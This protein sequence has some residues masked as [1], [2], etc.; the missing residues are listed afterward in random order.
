MSNSFVTPA[1]VKFEGLRSSIPIFCPDPFNVEAWQQQI[2]ALDE[3]KPP[4]PRFQP[5]WFCHF[6]LYARRTLT[7]LSLQLKPQY[8]QY[9]KEHEHKDVR[10]NYLDLVWM[11]YKRPWLFNP[12]DEEIAHALATKNTA[13]TK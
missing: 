4:S 9:S 7:G 3:T 5:T 8:K 11:M 1:M 12:G 13:P 10:G 6:D 2:S